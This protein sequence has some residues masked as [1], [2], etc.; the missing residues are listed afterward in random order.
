MRYWSH[1]NSSTVSYIAIPHERQDIGALDGDDLGEPD[2]VLPEQS[3]LLG[4]VLPEQ[5]SL[6]K[7]HSQEGGVLVLLLYTRFSIFVET[8]IEYIFWTLV[9]I[10]HCVIRT[11]A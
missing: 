1:T 5:P 2:L 11:R 4:S 9:N 6:E 7:K 3:P 8:L 10:E